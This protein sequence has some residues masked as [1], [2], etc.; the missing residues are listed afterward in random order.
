M[1]LHG[2]EEFPVA[3]AEILLLHRSAVDG[4]RRHAP[5]EGAVEDRPEVFGTL[6]RVVEAAAHLERHRHLW[7]HGGSHLFDDL[8]RGLRLR[9]Q[10]PA[11]AAAEHLLHRAAEVDIDD[12][13]AF[14]DE[15][16]GRRRKIV[17]I[18][19]HELSAHRMLLVGDGQTGEISAVGAHGC[20]ELVEQHFAE[21][22]GRAVTAGN[23][24]HRPVAV[25]GQCRLHDGG[26]EPNVSDRERPR[27]GGRQGHVSTGHWSN[28][29]RP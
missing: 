23:H 12:V 28:Q 15:P 25:T 10:E 13:V 24:P 3:R 1:P 8:E 17:G 16:L 27:R 2:S 22:V 4:D 18:R 7:R 19:P 29:V 26:L 9:E 5:S 21:G 20:H 11:S 14:G 6:L